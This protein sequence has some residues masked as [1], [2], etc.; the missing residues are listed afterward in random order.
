MPRLYLDQD[1]LIRLGRKSPDSAE[2]AQRIA[3]GAFTLVLSP[4]HWLETANGGSDDSARE[5]AR[6]MDRLRPMWLRERA[7]L[8]RLECQEFLEG[9]QFQQVTQRAVCRS[10]TELVA[11]MGGLT[12]GGVP[13]VDSE[14]VVME[15]RRDEN[16][17]RTFESSYDQ[18]VEAAECN[19][20]FFRIGK[21]T[22]EIELRARVI[23]LYRFSGVLEGSEQHL[24]LQQAPPKALRAL[25]CEWEA[26]K[27]YWRRDAGMAPNRLR[28]MFHLVVAMPHADL[29]LTYDKNLRTAIAEVA[30]QVPFPV[31][32]VVGSMDELIEAADRHQ[33]LKVGYPG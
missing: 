10:V 12:G 8:F 18:V 22:T 33:E 11:E 32:T 3:D 2:V 20:R 28:E 19:R 29:I 15:L 16:S 30:A 6:F 9:A 4:A 1:A 26:T 25:N 21:I 13:I 24:Q 23:I 5:L 17:R 14:A 27:W 31:A 7:K